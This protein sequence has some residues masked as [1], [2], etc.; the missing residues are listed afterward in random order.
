[1]VADDRRRSDGGAKRSVGGGVI[2]LLA[3]LGLVAGPAGASAQSLAGLILEEF[4]E[5]PVALAEVVL[6]T[7]EGDSV[8]AALTDENG[9]FAVEAPEAGRFYLVASAFGYRASRSERLDLDAGQ[10]RVVQLHL[11]LRPLPVEGVRVEAGPGDGPRVPELEARGFYDRLE[12]G[13]GEFLTPGQIAAHPGTYTPQLFREMTS[14]W[15]L[16]AQNGSRGPWSDR[17]W[18]RKREGRQRGGDG[19]PE[20]LCEPHLWVDDV[21]VELMPGEGLDDLV[22]KAQLEGVEVFVAPFGPP[23]RYLRDADPDRACGAILFWTNRR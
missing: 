17:V 5:E 9:Y 20:G 19:T 8:A 3:G 11:S 12:R 1:V 18:I 14:V 21:R 2:L 7:L 16:P 15:L 13:E 6:A 4:T 22:P 23:L 10:Q